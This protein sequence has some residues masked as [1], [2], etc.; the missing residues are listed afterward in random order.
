MTAA[1]HPGFLS[2]ATAIAAAGRDLYGRGWLPATSGNLSVRLDRNSFA[3]TVSGRDKGRLTA[4]D[5]MRVDLAGEPL[6]PGRPSAETLLHT[7]LYRWS[8]DI[9]AVLHTHGRTSTVLGLRHAGRDRVVLKGYELLKAFAGIETHATR[10]AFPIFENTQDI[11]ALADDV[12]ARLDGSPP[13]CYGY[14]IRGHGTY[15]WGRD[16]DEA[17]RHLE[18]LEYL[19][20]CELALTCSDLSE[21]TWA[22]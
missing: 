17:R 14:L 9:G 19:V 4:N 6:S 13:P 3:I 8:N 16:L 7:S 15:V 5:I 21:E 1:T 20:A 10:L 11:A 12:I 22:D 2:V 18:A